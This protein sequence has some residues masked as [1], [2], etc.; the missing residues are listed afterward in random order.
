[1]QCWM[2]VLSLF[3][4]AAVATT[5]GRERR[6]PDDNA[7]FPV[8]SNID[9]IQKLC[10]VNTTSCLL[11]ESKGFGTIPAIQQLVCLPTKSNR[12]VIY[13]TLV[14]CE[15]QTYADL[16]YSGLCGNITDTD[17]AT[18][19]TLCTDAILRYNNGAAAKSACCGT[20]AAEEEAGSSSNCQTELIRLTADLRCCTATI[21]LQFFF[22][23]CDDNSLDG[24]L[25]KYNVTRPDLCTY[26]LYESSVGA[27]V[28]LTPSL[29]SIILLA[30]ANWL[31][32]G[33]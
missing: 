30:I 16:V 17:G 21:I 8:T 5:K 24:V 12:D 7:C 20:D 14:G 25:Q 18:T 4:S 10:R 29:I 33:Y 19:D 26:P 22:E 27:R 31:W 3:L 23:D 13:N 32:P 2:V 28:T 11:S 9:N 1:M 6:Q 15:S